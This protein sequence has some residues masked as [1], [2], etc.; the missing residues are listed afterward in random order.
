MSGAAC[1]FQETVARAIITGETDSA[2]QSHVSVCPTCQEVTRV[3]QGMQGFA[4]ASKSVPALPN[5]S[6]LWWKAQVAQRESAEKRAR[7][8]LLLIQAVIYGSL[9]SLLAGW[10]IRNWSEIR[11]Q[12]AASTPDWVTSNLPSIPLPL[13]YL[14]LGFAC[15]SLVMVL[16]AVLSED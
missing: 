1:N 6:Y 8:L 12:M 4:S 2:I 9:I 7:R 5:A 14:S 13:V 10:L 16:R 3:A 15:I 11:Q